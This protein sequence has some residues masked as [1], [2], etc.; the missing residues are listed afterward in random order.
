MPVVFVHGVATRK[1]PGTTR[2]FVKRWALLEEILFPALGGGDAAIGRYEAFWGDAGAELWWGGASLPRAGG[3]RFGGFEP[4]GDDLILAETLFGGAVTRPVD[5]ARPLLDAA[6]GGLGQAVDLLWAYAEPEPPD[7]LIP[8]VASASAYA[9]RHPS[10][11]WLADCRDDE[12]LLGRL[13]DEVAPAEPGAGETFGSR[14]LV[15]RLREVG[16]RVVA[17]PGR[18]VSKPA[19]AARPLVHRPSAIFLGDVFE[20]LAQRGRAGAEGK[21]ARIVGDTIAEAMTARRPGDERLVVIAHSMGGNIVYDLLSDL[22]PE[23]ECDLLVTVGSQVALFAEL[24]MFGAVERPA[25]AERDRVPALPNVRRWI[26][27]YDQQDGLSFAGARVF[28]G[29]ED[30]GYSTGAGLLGAHSTYF[31]RPSFYQRLAARIQEGG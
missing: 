13:L 10:P 3:E 1:K 7:E 19:M 11:G 30:Y 16:A 20:Y 5:V 15:R 27:V 6:R 29:V 24:G 9:E 2:R 14:R 17:A 8:F 12:D 18:L 25:D 22:R 28:D 21:I 31:E 26:N 4:D 23:L